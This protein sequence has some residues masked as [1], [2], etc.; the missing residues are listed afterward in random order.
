M[1]SLQRPLYMDNVPLFGDM[2]SDPSVLELFTQ[3][4]LPRDTRPLD[5]A[6]NSLLQGAYYTVYDN[7]RSMRQ[8]METGLC[9]MREDMF[10]FIWYVCAVLC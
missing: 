3:Q 8:Q 7:L 10:Q 4:E 1:A 9:P 5:T 6:P 2:I